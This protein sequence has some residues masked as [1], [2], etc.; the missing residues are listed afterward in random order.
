MM[1][2]VNSDTQ[3]VLKLKIYI[4]QTLQFKHAFN[5]LMLYCF[6]HSKSGLKFMI[7]DNC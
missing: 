2:A 7:Q 1:R 6:A 3:F 5:V 4:L